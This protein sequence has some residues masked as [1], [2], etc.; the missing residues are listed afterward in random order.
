MSKPKLDGESRISQYLESL[1]LKTERY[2]K[3]ERRASRTPDFK[4]YSEDSLAFYCEVKTAQED[5]WLNS[6][7]EQAE[8]GTLVGGTRND[9][10]YNRIA[11]Y[12]H[13]S[14]GQFDAVNPTMELPNVLAIVNGD[15]DSGITDL[16]QVFTGNG[17]CD[18]GSVWPMYQEFSEG[19]IKESK[20]R[21]HLFMWFDE[22]NEDG[23]K[24]LVPESHQQHTLSLAPRLQID[25]RS[26]HRLPFH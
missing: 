5:T 17:Y 23:P 14:V 13:E 10:T 4:V 2:S 11:S 9:S 22:W 6:L 19:R 26:I 12:V 7:L 8:P 16:I 25:L 24:L 1:G 21:I 3:S 18:D 15:V 20:W